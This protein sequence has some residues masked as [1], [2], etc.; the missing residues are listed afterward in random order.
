[1]G[2]RGSWFKEERGR[3]VEA[4]T[5][6][7]KEEICR[8]RKSWPRLEGKFHAKRRGHGHWVGRGVRLTITLTDRAAKKLH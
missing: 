2:T 1:M 6:L 4:I 7:M 5:A 8:R 3:R